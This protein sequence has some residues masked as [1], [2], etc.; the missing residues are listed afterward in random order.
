[1]TS[2]MNKCDEILELTSLYLDDELD[3]VGRERMHRHMAACHD[4]SRLFGELRAVDM[5]FQQAPMRLAPA[6]FTARTVQ[7]VFDDNLRRSV[8]LGVLTLLLGTIVISS[9]VLLGYMELFWSAA[10]ILFAPG[11]LASPTHWMTEVVQALGVA[12]RVGLFVLDM[13]RGLLVGPLLVPSLLSLLA[14]LFL[15]IVL[16]QPGGRATLSA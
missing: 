16:R 12:W 10:A 4:C 6:H 9:I 5:L 3:E 1:M 8:M 15:G 14:A 13:L 7:A 2:E 11:F